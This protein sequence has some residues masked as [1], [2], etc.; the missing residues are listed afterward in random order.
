MREK[1]RV[2]DAQGRLRDMDEILSQNGF[3]STTD[4]EAVLLGEPEEALK[5]ELA[6]VK[7]ELDVKSKQCDEYLDLLQRAAAEFDNYKKRTIREKG[8]LYSNAV[9]DIVTTFL[10]VADSIDRA[11]CTCLKDNGLQVLK[12]GI[13]VISRQFDNVLENIGVEEI[14]CL[15][16]GFDPQFHNAVMHVEDENFGQNIVIEELQKGYI[17]KGKVIRH[18]IVRVAN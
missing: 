9:S 18:S 14:K 2:V 3:E 17:Y 4:A 10:P 11:K 12:E 5:K 7:S 15:N 1:R 16:E 8:T 13:E 6:V